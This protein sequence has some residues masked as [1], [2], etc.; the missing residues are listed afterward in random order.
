MAT[1]RVE[2]LRR[3]VEMER[4]GPNHGHLASP[5]KAAATSQTRDSAARNSPDRV[6]H[7]TP[8]KKN[9][10]QMDGLVRFK[11]SLPTLCSP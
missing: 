6:L 10:I 7:H 2:G 1:L 9:M 8:V 11:G 5:K 4:E 3:Q